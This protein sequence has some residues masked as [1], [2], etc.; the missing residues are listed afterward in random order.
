MGGWKV[1]CFLSYQGFR[2]CLSKVYIRASINLI[3]FLAVFY[4]MLLIVFWFMVRLGN[5]TRNTTA[6]DM[7]IWVRK[8]IQRVFV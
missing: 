6:R 8:F 5:R 3:E 4:H 2:I 7:L 1:L